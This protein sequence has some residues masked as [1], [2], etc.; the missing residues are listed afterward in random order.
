MDLVSR[1][2][3]FNHDRDP[4]FLVLKYQLMHEDKYRFFRA[5]THLFFEDIPID[6]FLHKA[7]PVWICGDLHLENFGSYK[8]DNRVA[9][10]NINDFD[11]CVLASPLLDIARLLTSIHV[12]AGSLKLS[13]KTVNGLSDIFINTY[14]DQLKAG[15]IRVLEAATTT[16]IINK[17]LEEVKDRKRKDFIAERTIREKGSIVLPVD[18]KRTAKINEKEKRI[19]TKAIKVW[20]ADMPAPCFF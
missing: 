14:F 6:S 2:K 20:A 9:Y 5:T 12:A 19:V 3:H 10:F 15:Y 7:P 13:S 8:S 11:E 18:N 4:D 17:F 16:G 1:I